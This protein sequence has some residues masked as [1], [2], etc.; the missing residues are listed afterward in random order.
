MTRSYIRVVVFILWMLL[1]VVCLAQSIKGTIADSLGKPVAFASVSLQ[2]S[3]KLII[4]YSTSSDKGIYTLAVPANADHTGLQLEVS[5]FGFKKQIKQVSDFAL[6]YNFKLSAETRQLQAVTIKDKRPRLHTNGDTLSY[7]VSDFS[8]PQDRVIGDVIKRLPGIDV[9]KD[10]KISYNGKPISNLY[11]GGDNL[12]DDKYNI[13]TSSIPNGVVDQVQ[14]LENNQPIKVLKDK[15]VTDDVA[16][17]LTIKKD[18]RLQLVG[19]ETIGAG[20]PGDYYEDLNAMMFKDKYKAINYIKGNNTG[21]D[22]A[23]DLVSHNRSGYLSRIDNDKPATVLSLGT[24]GDP[25]L[26]RNRYLF[27][28]S[29]ILNLN[30]LV[31]LKND[32]QLRVNLSYLR[33]NQ[34]Q[35]YRKTSEKYLPND[36][37]RYSE[38]QN[39]KRRPDI[40][41]SQF[42]VNINKSKYYLNDNLITDYS[43]NTGY[44]SLITNGVPVNQL[45]KDNLLDISNELN[46]MQTFK[47]NNILEVYSYLNHSGEPENRMIDPGLNP[48]LFNNNVNYA[49]LTQTANVPTFFTNNY[50][51]YKIPRQYVTQSYKVGFSA[52]AQSLNS[53]LAATQLNHTYNLVSDSAKNNLNWTRNKLYGEAGYDLP[54]KILKVNVTLPVYLMNIHYNDSFYNLDKNLTRLYFNP[55]LLVKYQSGIENYFN[56]NYNYRN[57]IGSIE[58]IYRGYILTDY[59]TLYANNADLTE[60]KT[61]T[62][63]IGF[64]Y[65]KAITLF[66]FSVNATYMHQNANNIT[67]SILTNNLQQ[68][69]VLPFDNNI[70][71]WMLN[72]YTSKYDFGLRTTFSGGIS[73][74]TTKLNQIQNGIILPYNT[75]NTTLSLGAETKLSDK[76]DFSYKANYSQTTSKSSAVVNSSKFERLIQTASVNYNP[77]SNLFLSVSGDHYYTHQQQSSDL[78]YLFADASIRYKFPKTKLDAELTAQNIFDTKNYTALYLAANVFTSSSYTIPGRIVLA[79]LLFNL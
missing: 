30:N 35:D 78:K 50:L 18:A 26:P 16:L 10:G 36:T 55:Q 22:V 17:N 39:N 46:V 11:I 34:R 29:G 75:I 60:S 15:V 61:Q 70:D 59:R 79:K 21:Y 74:Q 20:L 12:L 53:A 54:G 31:N 27:N 65:H 24:A 6:P 43:H 28:Q 62:A 47:T 49:Q 67:S 33:D 68:R 3:S 71:S 8:N 69:I 57:T 38:I 66:F 5:S 4:A 45:F 14:V 13:A 73:L 76:M 77:K 25:D 51:S 48:Q 44:S 9:A 72:G 37:V 63:S 42:T 41:H 1:P 32:V 23:G 58:D 64:N 19:Q 7:N 52:Q 2:N 40:L 56:I